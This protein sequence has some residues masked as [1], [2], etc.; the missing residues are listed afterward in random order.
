MAKTT[1]L[2]QQFFY[3]GYDLS[4]DV[5]SIESAEATH[6]T[7][8]VTG[9]NVASVERLSTRTGGRLSYTHFFN[10]ATAAA[11]AAHSGLPTADV[12]ALWAVG[13]SLGD[14]AYAIT[15]KQAS[16]AYSRGTDM[17][18]VGTTTLESQGFPLE[19][20]VMLTAGL[21]TD[22]S[23]TNGTSVDNGAATSN[24]IVGH[25]QFI[26]I[27]GSNCTVTIQESS[28]DGS[29]DAFAA[30]VAFTQVTADNKFERKTA[31]GAVERYLRVISAG[32]FSSAKFVVAARRGT[33]EDSDAIS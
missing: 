22:T 32:T 15:A 16:H 24:G 31:T 4:G 20:V 9:I 17:S 26:D 18:F 19:D 7:V 14:S 8:D 13:T 28:D 1:G 5:G 21:R 3:A 6:E 10:D 30:I 27:T 25:L 23:A 29:G 12:A 2:S 11:H 33:A